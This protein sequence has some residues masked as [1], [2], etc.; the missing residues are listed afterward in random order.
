MLFAGFDSK[1]GPT[2]LTFTFQGQQYEH[3][4]KV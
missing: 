3:W 2:Q 4:K 1:K